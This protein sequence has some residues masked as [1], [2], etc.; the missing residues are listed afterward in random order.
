MWA[1]LCSDG[2]GEEGLKRRIA[3]W[4]GRYKYVCSGGLLLLMPQD[5]WKGYLQLMSLVLFLIDKNPAGTR[6][7]DLAPPV[8]KICCHWFCAILK[9]SMLYVLTASSSL[10][11]WHSRSQLVSLL[12]KWPFSA[13]WSSSR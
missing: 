10:K 12:P 13:R 4:G 3:F 8:I 5:L 9:A 1:G 2:E 6:F 7:G 11:Q